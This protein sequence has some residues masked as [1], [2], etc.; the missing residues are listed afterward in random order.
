MFSQARRFSLSVRQLARSW[1]LG[2]TSS[3]EPLTSRANIASHAR[4]APW[5]SSFPI[6]GL[7][8][9][10]APFSDA[11]PVSVIVRRGRFVDG[12]RS[13]C[14][15]GTRRL[16]EEPSACDSQTPEGSLS[17]DF[18]APHHNPRRK[19]YRFGANARQPR[20]Q[21]NSR[22]GLMATRRRSEEGDC[23][24]PHQRHS[25]PSSESS[26]SLASSSGTLHCRNRSMASR[27]PINSRA[28]AM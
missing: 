23:A 17:E 3:S 16:A 11:V 7:W 6:C 28:V 4:Q 2:L 26:T 10:P 20:K 15:F 13:C 22:V 18:R 27:A 12:R 14:I 5:F 9:G 1:P 25:S 21:T 8:A 19:D 24:D